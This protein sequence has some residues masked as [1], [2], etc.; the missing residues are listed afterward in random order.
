MFSNTVNCHSQKCVCRA[1]VCGVI[2]RIVGNIRWCKYSYELLFRI[3]N[4]RT[5]QH[6][7]VEPIVPGK[8][9]TRSL[10]F[11]MML[12]NT[13]NTKISTIRKLLY[14]NYPLTILTNDIF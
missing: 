6:S 7:D 4:M 1:C 8:C 9:R 2:F 11:R 12:Y 5:A 13:K 14:E 10:N 3:L